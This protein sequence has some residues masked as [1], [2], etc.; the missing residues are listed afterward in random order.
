[1]QLSVA[2]VVDGD[3]KLRFDGRLNDTVSGPMGCIEFAQ[4]SVQRPVE[5]EQRLGQFGRWTF[6]HE[7]V[8]IASESLE[9][10]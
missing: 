5:S 10:G 2:L 9:N 1:M 7:S 3:G 4:V 6:D 8:H